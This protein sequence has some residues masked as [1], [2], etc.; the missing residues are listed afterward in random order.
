MTTSVSKKF[1]F[2]GISTTQRNE[3]HNSIVKMKIWSY[4]SLFEFI[5]N[6][7]IVLL[8]MREKENLLNHNDLF[9]PPKLITPLA[10]EKSLLGLY[11]NKVFSDYQEEISHSLYYV[12]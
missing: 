4:Y 8:K 1:F 2:A 9:A 7:D 10:I 11:T 3:G 5:G 12:I 6:L